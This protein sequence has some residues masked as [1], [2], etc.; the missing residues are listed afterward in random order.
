MEQSIGK[1]IFHIC[2]IIGM[3]AVLLIGVG[4]LVLLYQV[5]GE[6][7]LPFQISKIAI[8]SSVNGKDNQDE[9]NTWNLTV[10]QNNDIYL[11][12]DKNKDYNKTEIIDNIVINNISINKQVQK[13]EAH[14]YK[15]AETDSELFKNS[16]ENIVQE[17]TYTGDMESN[18]KNLKIAN[19]GGLVVMRFANDNIAT[20]V[21]SEGEQVDH[22]KLLQLTN[23]NM[24]ELKANV[25]FDLSINLKSG[26]SFK[27]NVALDIPIEGVIE[28]GTASK[29]ITETNNIIF[30]RIENN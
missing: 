7:N 26:K 14:V 28:N 21:S 11:Y 29:E 5:E 22:S 13:G 2:M 4:V 8:I 20:Y 18:I 23:T 30:K 27:A 19:Q 17:L 10:N 1:K 3:I 9:A 24:E 6:T 12:I 15:P 16:E 25:T